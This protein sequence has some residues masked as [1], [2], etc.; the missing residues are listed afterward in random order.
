MIDGKTERNVGRRAAFQ[1]GAFSL[2]PASFGASPP[3][4]GTGAGDV[5]SALGGLS[6]P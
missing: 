4:A 5:P 3:G 1:P 6:S 2:D